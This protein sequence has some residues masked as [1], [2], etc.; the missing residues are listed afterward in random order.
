MS[1][2]KHTLSFQH[3]SAPIVEA[4]TKFGGQPVWI[5][6][7]Q[8]PLSQ[9]WGDPM[10]FI[11]QIRLDPEL[12]GPL[13]AQM[14]YVFMTDHPDGG[15]TWEPDGG[16][17]AVILQPGTWTG[18]SLPLR[19]GPSLWKLFY[20]DL[21][22]SLETQ[23][24]SDLTRDYDPKNMSRTMK[25]PCEYA[26]ELHPGTDS[27][28]QMRSWI[29]ERDGDEDEENEDAWETYWQA[30][31]ETKIG[32]L[33]VPGPNDGDLFSLLPSR[34]GDSWHFLLQLPQTG[35]MHAPFEVNFASGNGY[36]FLSADGKVGKFLWTS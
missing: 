20:P 7:P 35:G 9:Q 16:E 25:L 17:N 22:D 2:P 15:I 18:P 11:C 10:Q 29:T 26:V 6:E 8:W 3:V 23:L 34:S 21:F 12:F 27:E 14:A 31:Q 19:E 33:P 32:G 30:Y 36:V 5:G 1:V 13:E 28:E 4:V 24:A